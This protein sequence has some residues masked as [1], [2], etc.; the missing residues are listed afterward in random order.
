MDADALKH[1]ISINTKDPSALAK[2]SSLSKRW[3]EFTTGKPLLKEVGEIVTQLKSLPKVHPDKYQYED[4]DMA[5]YVDL[6][7]W[8]NK[9]LPDTITTMVGT[10]RYPLVKRL[11]IWPDGK[12][13][14]WDQYNNY[15]KNNQP[16]LQT[17][18][19]IAQFLS[20]MPDSTW[21]NNA[22]DYTFTME[23]DQWPSS[24][25]FDF[26]VKST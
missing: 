18:Q 1:A 3:H 6:S 24:R 19:A 8:S 9:D 11:R 10:L 17:N 22:K 21:Q 4:E 7:F 20:K 13:Y 5:S 14:Y 2:F 16:T 25:P 26:N 23:Y 12:S 15:K